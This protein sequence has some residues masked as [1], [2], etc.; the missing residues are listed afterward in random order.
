MNT[1]TALKEQKIISIRE[2]MRN[3]SKITSKPE[4]KIYTLVKN[5]K[6]VGTYIPE[7]YENYIWPEQDYG[8][9]EEKEYDSLF[10]NYKNMVVKGGDPHLSQKIDQILYGKK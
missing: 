3:M 7:E 6:K 8:V 9:G 1:L 4:H 2:F 5:G 10:D